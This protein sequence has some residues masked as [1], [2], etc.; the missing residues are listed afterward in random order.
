MLEFD[1]KPAISAI[2]KSN[3]KKVAVQFPEG[4]K[5]AITRISR[6]IEAKTDAKTIAFVEPCF[7]ACDI[8]DEEAKRLGAE[9]LIHLGH[10]IFVQKHSLETIYLPLEYKP[11]NKTLVALAE[12]VFEKI[13]E[14]RFKRI[15]LCSTAQFKK[16]RKIVEKELEKKGIK[17]FAGKGKNIEPGQVLGCNYSTVK[18]VEKDIEA[19][20]FVGDGL[21]HPIG[22][23]FAT[24]KPVFVL[25][26]GQGEI[27]ELEKQK[28]LFLRK[29]IAMIE[30][31][32]Q[33]K[34]IAIWVSTKK[35]QEKTALAIKLKEKFE[36]KGKEAIV[37]SSSLLNPSHIIGINTDAIVS[38]ACPRIAL[39]DSSLFKQ[40]IVNPTE[41]LIAL[42]E[43]KL[44]EYAFDEL[45]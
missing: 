1:L 18:A 7:G 12:Q 26:P 13:S 2:K 27:K 45:A 25:E 28:D 4:L 34:K 21:F 10:T 11:D 19:V 42:G 35:G 41:A 40:P 37:I 20:I 33:A 23:N 36:A 8:L 44:E 9:L 30:K 22:L 17:V 6:E 3:A 39:D 14:K 15:A 24:K 38:T 43:K 16:H 29:R 32:R 5:T 31:T